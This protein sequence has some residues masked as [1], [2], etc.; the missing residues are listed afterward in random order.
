MDLVELKSALATYYAK[1]GLKQWLGDNQLLM[2]VPEDIWKGMLE[3][4]STVETEVKKTNSSSALAINYF[5]IL[6][7][8]SGIRPEY[9]VAV[10]KPLDLPDGK[11]RPAMIDVKYETA[12][13]T[14]Y[15]ESKFLEPYYSSTHEISPSYFVDQYYNNATSAAKWI[16]IFKKVQIMIDSKEFCYYD[17]N[18][19]L[20]HLL[21]I[22]RTSPTKPVILKNLIWK[23]TEPF[24]NCIDSKTSVSYLKK[25]CEKLTEEMSVAEALL[26]QIVTE[27]GWKDC[28]IEVKYY[29]DELDA[30]KKHC[31]L[32]K[33]MNKYML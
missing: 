32:E 16:K 18:Q 33:F 7:E 25:R 20:K 17:I 26:N 9:E 30:I 22:Y 13:A 24:F 31:L 6:S 11:G 2:Q 28:L 14:I 8:L 27:L 15:V 3:R 21:A 1:N 12:A 19:M 29:N 4:N 23:P 10:H 5:Q